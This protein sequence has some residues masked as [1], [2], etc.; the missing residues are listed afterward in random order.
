MMMALTAGLA[1]SYGLYTWYFQTKKVPVLAKSGEGTD[2]A[3]GVPV[4]VFNSMPVNSKPLEHSRAVK[5]GS[6]GNTSSPSVLGASS[7]PSSLTESVKN[8]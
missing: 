3:S 1:A 7:S 2:H 6:P 8:K 5:A 4:R